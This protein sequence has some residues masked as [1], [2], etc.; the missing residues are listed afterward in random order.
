M[1]NIILLIFAALLLTTPAH[2]AGPVRIALLQNDIHHL[3]FWVALDQGL[4]TEGQ[5]V[6]VVGLFRAGPEIMSAFAAGA[7][8]M[9]YVGL[10]PSVTAVANN[11]AQIVVVSQAN[12]VGSALVVGVDAPQETL[13]DLTGKTIAV[14]GHA[15]VQDFLIKQSLSAAGIPL[16]QINIMVLRPP[17]MI[18]AL[19][20]GQIDGFIAWEPYPSLAATLNVGRNLM[21]SREMWPAHPC[22]GVV[23]SQTFLREQAEKVRAVVTA[24][25]QATDFILEHPEKAV[26]IGAR[27]TG[28][29][30]ETIRRAMQNV[31]FDTRLNHESVKAY[32]QFLANLGYIRVADPDAFMSRFIDLP[33]V[34]N[35]T[36]P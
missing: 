21:T 3:A 20:T 31:D 34:A 33:L 27:H 7:L 1:R 16:N 24:H 28:L 36:E 15:T 4:L 30:T 32:V 9:A 6:E 23:A 12:A 25:H 29:D 5:D 18:G 13:A 11:T 19:R 2:T 14:P 35:T 22:C 26:A 10:A 8:D 17:E